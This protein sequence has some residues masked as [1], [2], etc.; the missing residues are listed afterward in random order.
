MLQNRATI[1]V[2]KPG[3]RKTLRTAFVQEVIPVT[4]VISVFKKDVHM[5]PETAASCAADKS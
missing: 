2:H 3:H 4:Q 5:T 1:Y